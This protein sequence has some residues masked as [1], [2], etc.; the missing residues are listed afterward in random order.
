MN[1]PEPVTYFEKLMSPLPFLPWLLG[2]VF[3]LAIFIWVFMKIVNRF[4]TPSYNIGPQLQNRNVAVAVY[5]GL[6]ILGVIIVLGGF[7]ERAAF[8]RSFDR[9]SPY[10]ASFRRA[11]ATFFGSSYSWQ[12]FKAQGQAESRLRPRVCS[13]VGACGIMQIMPATARELR[14]NPF[15]AR[16][17]I[18]AGIKYDRQMWNQWS[19]PR[20]AWDRLAFALASYNA[21][22]RNVLR[23]QEKAGGA[24]L[25]AKVAE[26]A[27]KEPRN[28]VL[29][30]ARWC[31]RFGGWGCTPKE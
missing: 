28:Y 10:D 25:W 23:F 19:L 22:L 24:N 16:A 2:A 20:P 13:P 27:W 31:A 15:N 8:G 21:G 9:G 14:V 11:A 26:F 30:I 7:M 17:S 3:A 12:H 29:R 18:W 1:N 5:W 4:M 6:I